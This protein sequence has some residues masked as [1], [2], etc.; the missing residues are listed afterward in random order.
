MY[1]NSQ[2][3]KDW[4]TRVQMS[5]PVGWEETLSQFSSFSW[6]SLISHGFGLHPRTSRV[7]RVWCTSCSWVD[8]LASNEQ[9]IWSACR[10]SGPSSNTTTPLHSCRHCCP[11]PAL[12]H[13]SGCRL[14]WPLSK[15]RKPM[16][17]T[18][19][20]TQKSCL[21]WSPVPSLCGSAARS[22]P[23]DLSVSQFFFFF[24]W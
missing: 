19:A 21:G 22:E 5:D 18:W 3:L 6:P 8:L 13:L 17:R 20:W 15:A 1:L 2:E 12:G 14:L 11:A 23:S 9:F 16:S 24:H 4:V 7:T 10:P